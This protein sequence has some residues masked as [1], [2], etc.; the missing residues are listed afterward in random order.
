MKMIALFITLGVLGFFGL[1]ALCGTLFTVKQQTVAIITRF[2]KF[3]NVALPGLNTKC[4]FIDTIVKRVSLR[5]QQL[6]VKVETKTK[7]NV[8]VDT[9]VS[10]QYNVLPDKVV[11][12]FYKL[13]DPAQQI[14]SYV[15]DLVRAEIPKLT[16]DEVFERKDDVANAVKKELSEVMDDFGYGIIK[17]LVTDIDPDKRV[18][19]S[20]NS[21]NAAQRDRVAASEKGEAEKI[22]KVK[23]AEAEAMSKKL[24][25]QGIADQRQAI[26]N[27]LK[28]SVVE[29]Q[30]GVP[31]ST[32]QDVM[33]LVLVT[34]YFDML[35][36]LGNQSRTSTVFL[37]HSPGALSDLKKL[38]SQV[39]SPNQE[40]KDEKK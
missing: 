12:A 17:A 9:K 23:Q 7:D 8:F 25:G 35:K 39:I 30:A 1:I 31:G 15:F 14:T 18:K 33:N 34:Q 27:G 26:V 4:P 3:K 2:G 38:L 40:Q 6:D 10:V 16:L 21:I 29:F 37:D 22:L 20:M 19:D 13:N 28:E 5:I 32:A 36:D 11:E 24:Q